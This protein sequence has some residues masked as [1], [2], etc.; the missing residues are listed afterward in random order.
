MAS[1]AGGETSGGDRAAGCRVNLDRAVGRQ[2]Y[3]IEVMGDKQDMTEE[4]IE[5]RVKR[6]IVRRLFLKMAPESIEENKSLMDDYGVDSVSLLELVVGAEE[7]FGI[8]I[9]DEDFDIR[10][11]QTVSAL[12]AFVRARMAKG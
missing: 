5:D 4:R 2:D 6:L 3:G 8:T 11:F 9:P 7:E 10:H 1:A 12:A